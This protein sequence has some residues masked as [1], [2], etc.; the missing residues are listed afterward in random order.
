MKGFCII[1]GTAIML[2]LIVLDKEYIKKYKLYGNV[3]ITYII[4]VLAIYIIL[5]NLFSR[6]I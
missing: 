6:S 5:T 4:T 3:V 2:M 1:I